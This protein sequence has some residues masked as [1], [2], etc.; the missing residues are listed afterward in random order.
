M[1]GPRRRS[2][3]P[4]HRPKFLAI[5]DDT[6]ECSRA[7]RYATRRVART[8]SKLVLLTIIP[9]QEAPQLLGVAALM[10]AEAEAEAQELLDGYVAQAQAIASVVPE[11]ALRSGDRAAAI[12]DLI[13]KDED[14]AVLVLAAGTGKEG[15][16]P[17]VELLAG[18][19]SGSFPI[20]IAIVPGHLTDEEIDSM[21]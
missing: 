5:A 1:S 12:R 17:L 6:P 9:P 19:A 4:G 18:K 21:A 3:E 15:P 2:Y 7:V 16:G 20:P 10:K 13:A 8:G 14:I 11:T